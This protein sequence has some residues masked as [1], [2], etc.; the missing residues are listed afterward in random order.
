MRSFSIRA[1]AASATFFAPSLSV[2]GSTMAN[3]SPPILATKSAA[4]LLSWRACAICFR[5]SSPI[6]CPK[7][8]L[9]CLKKSTSTIVNASGLPT[10]LARAH[11]LSKNSSKALRLATP[12]SA[13]VV[14]KV[15]SCSFAL[16]SNSLRSRTRRC[17]R[18]KA[19]REAKISA[20]STTTGSQGVERPLDFLLPRRERFSWIEGA[21]TGSWL[22]RLVGISSP[23]DFLDLFGAKP[24]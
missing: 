15:E 10:R 19:M 24:H 1:R 20:D 21:R 14:A 22:R 11:S 12:V 9:Y 6:K 3:S 17:C 5:H 4:R 23:I 7:K 18:T 8:S 13:S 16:R 2:S